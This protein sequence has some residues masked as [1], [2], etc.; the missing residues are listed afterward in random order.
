MHRHDE[1]RAVPIEIR[2]SQFLLGQSRF[3]EAEQV[4]QSADQDARQH[5]VESRVLHEMAA[6]SLAQIR[7]T[8]GKSK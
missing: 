4:V 6:K 1:A 2:L 3:A 7:E 8:K 5:L